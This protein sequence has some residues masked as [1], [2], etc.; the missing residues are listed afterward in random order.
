MVGLSQLT[1]AQKFLLAVSLP[2]TLVFLYFLFRRNDDEDEEDEGR[3]KVVT[4]QHTTVE[5][6]VPSH[7]VGAVIGQQ[8]QQI[9]QIQELTKTRI[10]FKGESSSRGEDRTAVIRGARDGVHMAELMIRKIIVDQPPTVD[11]SIVVPQSAVGRII[12]RNGDTIRALT[13]Q[14]KAKITIARTESRN[15]DAEVTVQ[16]QGVPLAVETA[17]MLILEK[18]VEDA[19]F[20]AKDAKD[21]H[22]GTAATDRYNTT[23]DRGVDVLTSHMTPLGECNLVYV[24]SVEHPQHFWV[25]RLTSAST[26]LDQL[27]TQM[28]DYY[29]NQ[30]QGQ[31]VVEFHEGDM[32]AAPYNSDGHWYRAQVAQVGVDKVDLYYV[33]FGDSLWLAKESV[34]ILR[35]DFLNVLPFQAIECCLTNVKPAN[36]EE[37]MTSAIDE[38][39][40]LCHVGNWNK[41]LTCRTVSET[42]TV[43]GSTLYY[44]Q[45]IDTN[46]PTEVDI[47]SELVR[48][49][50]A[51]SITSLSDQVLSDDQVQT[52]FDQVT[53]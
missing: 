1:P 6:L 16:L 12:G 52:S 14:S 51:I 26:D 43:Y 33:D 32:V 10:N 42:Q 36:G 41:A 53:C 31:P 8:G 25:Q 21:Q 4:S 34:C 35:E 18:V 39:E 5:L 23:V 17:K 45:L 13:R 47:G 7:A 37:W 48:L 15:T 9:R 50:H 46:A 2:I 27:M 30:K 11:E 38:F 29:A 19:E 49:G 24:T 3:T 22:S 20:R 40:T 44:I 28:T